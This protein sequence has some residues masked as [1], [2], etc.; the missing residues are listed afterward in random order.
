MA[1]KI[2]NLIKWQVIFLFIFKFCFCSSA[3]V[4]MMCKSGYDLDDLL[5][6]YSNFKKLIT[7][8]VLRAP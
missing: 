3:G 5:I 2:N 6:A 1:A 4:K 7:V 8:P